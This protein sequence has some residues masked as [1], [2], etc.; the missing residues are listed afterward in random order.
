MARLDLEATKVYG[1]VDAL[2]YTSS[3]GYDRQ[4][5]KE[6]RLMNRSLVWYL[7][8]PMS[9]IEFCNMPLFD[10]ATAHLRAQGFK[11]ISPG[12]LDSPDVRAEALASREGIIHSESWGSLLGRDV[13][14]VADKV[15]GLILLPGFDRSRG[16]RLEVFVG[17]LCNKKFGLYDPSTQSAIPAELDN[18]RNWLRR[19]I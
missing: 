9:G 12:E 18:I 14:I 7:C 11:I 8:G 2:H 17:I 5:Q 3:T 13:A 15:G 19:T 6:V 16:A 4:L 10:S 1:E